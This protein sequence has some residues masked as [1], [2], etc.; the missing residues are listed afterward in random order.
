MGLFS[1]WPLVFLD[2]KSASQVFVR[3]R[4][5]NTLLEEVKPGNLERECIEEVCNYEEAREVYEN[6]DTAV[7]E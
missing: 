3:P 2:P 4:R 6:T 5:A 7:R 1:H